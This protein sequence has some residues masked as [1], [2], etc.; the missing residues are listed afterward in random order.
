MHRMDAMTRT[1]S[2]ESQTMFRTVRTLRL[3]LFV[4]AAATMIGCGDRGRADASADS[5]LARDLT[6]AGQTAVEPALT[7]VA[8]APPPVATPPVRSEPRTVPQR[9]PQ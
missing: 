4:A 2:R 3:T 9:T 1:L 5:A 8:E 6:L 7:D